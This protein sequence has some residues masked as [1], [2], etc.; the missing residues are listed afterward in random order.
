VVWLPLSPAARETFNETKAWEY[1]NGD[2]ALNYGFGNMLW[3]WVDFESD[4]YPYPVTWQ[5]HELLPAWLGKLSQ[6]TSDLMWN[7]AFNLRAGTK[8]LNTADVYAAAR[9]KGMPNFG[10][11]VTTPESDEWLWSQP[12]NNGTTVYGHSSVC[13]VFV[14]RVWKSAGLFGDTDFQCTEATNW[15]VY[16]LNIFQ[17]PNPL[18]PQCVAADPELPFCQLTGKYRLDLPYWNTRQIYTNSFN[19]CPRG[20]PPDWNK[21]VGC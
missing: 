10:A 9:A 13:D 11:L 16:T 15:D 5:A 14:C 19:A 1:I 12:D 2:L 8:G 4:N 7:Q 3:G 21:P 20:N 18:P 17:A 6:T